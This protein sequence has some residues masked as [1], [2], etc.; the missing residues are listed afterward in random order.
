M[1][2]CIAIGLVGDHDPAI[3]A[4]QAIP[5]ALQQA[6][7]ALRLPVAFGWI[8]STEVTSAARVA[9]FHGL[10][11]VPGSPY[12]SM[13]GALC[14][15]RHARE[16]GIPFLGTCGGFQHAVI[17]YARN[18]L[19]WHDA[20][21]A[22][23]RPGASRAVIES[24]ACSL[25]E[26]RGQVSLTADSHLA[27]AYAALTATEG[28]RCNYGLN[29]AFRT[30]LLAG[31]LRATAVDE[32]GE[33]RAVELATHPFFVATLFQPERGALAGARVPLVDAFLQA[34]AASA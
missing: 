27:A 17:E 8:P 30:T 25:V 11:C 4:H 20:E 28:Y 16:Q 22:E 32:Q 3:I 23:T 9:A 31:A 12:R 33:V 34:C 5:L 13:E 19:G 15:I 18:V 10:W 7:G 26:V 1:R 21:H 29:P 14:A 6:A 24:L 2:D